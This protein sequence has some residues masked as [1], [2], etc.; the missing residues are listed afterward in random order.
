MKL[1]A[2][3]H[4]ISYE[5]KSNKRKIH[6]ARTSNRPSLYLLRGLGITILPHALVKL[7]YNIPYQSK[8]DISP[9]NSKLL[10]LN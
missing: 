5:R 10:Y 4:S 8:A 2:R 1:N 3:Q 7:K 6:I 9:Q